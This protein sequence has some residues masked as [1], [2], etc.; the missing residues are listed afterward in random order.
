M[1]SRDPRSGS[2][3]CQYL[4]LGPG[5]K[6]EIQLQRRW[7][8]VI[9]LEM[10]SS[11]EQHIIFC[12]SEIFFAKQGKKCSRLFCSHEELRGELVEVVIFSGFEGGVE[13]S[14]CSFSLS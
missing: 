13:N 8:P 11:G 7:F 3:F 9:G 14:L 4:K 10:L 12:A 2:E 1:A 5:S 6:G